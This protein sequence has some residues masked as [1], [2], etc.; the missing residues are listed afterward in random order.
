MIHNCKWLGKLGLVAVGLAVVLGSQ[1]C[2]ETKMT[3]QAPAKALES[4]APAPAVEKSE[5]ERR[6]S[7]PGGEIA[8][9][10]SRES[11]PAGSAK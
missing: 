10:A 9:E 7:S 2:E 11:L 4:T 6:E 3:E 8:P 1:A 5:P